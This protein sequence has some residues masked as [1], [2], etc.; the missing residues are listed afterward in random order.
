MIGFQF[1]TLMPNYR[2]LRMYEKIDILQFEVYIIH[3]L[4]NDN[5]NIKLL[6]KNELEVQ[7]EL[8]N[9]NNTI[10][11][12]IK[13]KD[14]IL[15]I[16]KDENKKSFLTKIN[17]S[18][19][20]LSN[21]LTLTNHSINEVLLDSQ[22]ESFK[23][24]I[25][26]GNIYNYRTIKNTNAYNLILN[27]CIKLKKYDTLIDNEIYIIK[28]LNLGN[29]IF[30]EFKLINQ[31]YSS[32]YN[33][34]NNK[35]IELNELQKEYNNYIS[36]I[37]TFNL[38][39]HNNIK[40]FNDI[41]NSSEDYSD[42]KELLYV[43]SSQNSNKDFFLKS[44]YVGISNI[45]ETD[46]LYFH[47]LKNKRE[48]F[49]G[50]ILDLNQKLK[51]F[52]NNKIISYI[53]SIININDFYNKIKLNHFNYRKQ[54]LA[55]ENPSFEK[56]R[57]YCSNLVVNQVANDIEI[58][59]ANNGKMYKALMYDA[60]EQILIKINNSSI[61]L[62]DFGCKQ[63]INSLL[64]LDYIREKQLDI[65]IKKIFLVDD[66]IELLERAK[67]HVEIFR[68]N[69]MEV[70][71]IN[72]FQEFKNLNIEKN[73][74]T[75]NLYFNDEFIKKINLNDIFLENSY[76]ICISTRSK[77]YND[78]IYEAYKFSKI[79]TN[80]EKKIGKFKKYELIFNI[81]QIPF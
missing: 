64:L 34:I 39:F 66:N 40:I 9:D 69:D 42:T 76:H 12:K 79:I 68:N 62:I 52:K 45:V 5:M 75:I 29:E 48:Y 25:K 35:Y 74:A 81:E 7:F 53:Y 73:I 67:T 72:N 20:S 3:K 19:H 70:L 71:L 22:I 36:K 32:I 50:I 18:L 56:I 27:N 41:I 59:L 1:E 44:E 17:D 6:S 60:F 43:Y 49:D 78:K 14:D 65:K 47:E 2:K 4:L 30:L 31:E 55:I 28:M 38:Y 26:Y 54:I 8:Y 10:F 24:T 61:N 46:F 37:N 13:L 21:F 15:F 23:K 11:S 58:D 77:E 63:G 80:E 51:I 16:N 33:E 57:R